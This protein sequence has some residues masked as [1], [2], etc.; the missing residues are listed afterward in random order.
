MTVLII[1]LVSA[2]LAGFFFVRHRFSKL[3]PWGTPPG[4]GDKR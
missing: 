3:R 1:C 2:L 4:G